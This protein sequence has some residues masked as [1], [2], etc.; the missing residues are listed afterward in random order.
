VINGA[1]WLVEEITNNN[2]FSS[3]FQMTAPQCYWRIMTLEKH[4]N[5]SP[6]PSPIQCITSLYLRPLDR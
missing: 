1:M 3:F 6:R 4:L 2:L 5:R